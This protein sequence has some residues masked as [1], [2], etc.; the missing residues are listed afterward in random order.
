MRRDA[1]ARRWVDASPTPARE[2][3]SVQHHSQRL[4]ILGESLAERWI[5]QRGWIVLARRFE[6]GHR[7]IDLIVRR[8]E[9]VAFIEVKTR[10]RLG[11]GGPI[12]AVSAQKR[13]HLSHAAAIWIDRYGERG[14]EYRFDVIGVLVDAGLVR[15]V[16]VENAFLGWM[17]RAP[18]R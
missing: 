1:D 6:V 3:A 17:R 4:G 10:R 9:T 12:G 8:G 5:S 16:Y 7:D 18:G 11:F 14:W 2:S 15:V 13:R